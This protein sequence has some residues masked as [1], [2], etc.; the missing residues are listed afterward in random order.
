[1]ARFLISYRISGTL[2]EVVNATDKDEAELIATANSVN[3]GWA[4]IL[5]RIEDVSFQIQ[6]F[7]IAKASR[8]QD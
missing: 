3:D 6:Q 1:M 7:S 5:D 8:S 4:P 2:N